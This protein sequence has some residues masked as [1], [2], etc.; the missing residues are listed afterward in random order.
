MPPRELAHLK[1]HLILSLRYSIESGGCIKIRGSHSRDQSA[2]ADA[3]R[4]QQSIEF[5][6]SLDF[7]KEGQSLDFAKEGW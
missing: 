1:Q 3:I 6:Q 4:F 5:Q 2:V 7:A